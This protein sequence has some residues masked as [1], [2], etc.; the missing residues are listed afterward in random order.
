MSAQPNPLP[1]RDPLDAAGSPLPLPERP[2]P[3][4]VPVEEPERP[5]RKRP[6]GWSALMLVLLGAGAGWWLYSQTDG[7]AELM[8]ATSGGGP[9]GAI[10][11]T[12]KVTTG[13]LADT[14]RLS[15]AVAAQS[16]AAIR[17]PQIR[18]GRRSQGGGGA[19]GLTLIDMVEPGVTVQKGQVVAEFDRQ[20]QQQ[21]IDDQEASVVQAGAVIDSTRAQ[22]MIERETKRQEMVTAQA[23]F[24]KAKMDLRTASVRSEIERT[25][26]PSTTAG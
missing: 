13:D 1:S 21:T 11:R 8:T 24:E 17:A 6:G 19:G 26:S 23:E 16:F 15:G 4:P 22:L 14:I 3:R 12:A 10:V 7:A 18:R 2:A 5:G 25:R 9:G 20:S